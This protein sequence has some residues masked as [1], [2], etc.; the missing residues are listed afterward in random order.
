MGCM[1]LGKCIYCTGKEITEAEKSD[2]EIMV[3]ARAKTWRID[4]WK[5]NRLEAHIL[6]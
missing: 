1:S 2:T 5:K 3:N 6:L 4:V